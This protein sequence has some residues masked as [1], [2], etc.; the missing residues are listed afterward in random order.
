MREK[1]INTSIAL[2]GAHGFRETSIEDITKELGVTKGTFYY[3]FTNKEDVLMHIHL[4][5][6]E[7][8]LEQQKA[9]LD[10][11]SKTNQEKLHDNVQMVIRNIRNGVQ[12]AKV[13]FREMKH[14]NEHH[15]SKVL[16]KRHEFQRNIQGI[17][18]R[19]IDEGEFRRDLRADMLSFAVLGVANWS[20]F[21][22]EPDGEV[23]EDQLT[24]IY[25]RMIIE[26][27][28]TKGGE[29]DE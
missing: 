7:G 22:F 5:F 11:Q 10:N 15:T 23:S 2:F 12:S 13:F 9:I 8:L 4:R 20:Y 6:I 29:I 1:I 26:G 24:D 3:Y 27:I 18:Q 21:W 28:Q 14:L 25:M 17:I 19:G 16:P